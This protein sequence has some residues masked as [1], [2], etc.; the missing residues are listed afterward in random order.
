M[1][2][3]NAFCLA[4]IMYRSRVA[5]R[6]IPT[7]RLIGAPLLVMSSTATLFDAWEQVSSNA[8]PLGLRVRFP[9]PAPPSPLPPHSSRTRECTPACTIPPTSSS[10]RSLARRWRTSSSLRSSAV[11]PDGPT[12]ERAEV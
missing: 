8:L 6:I 10:E 9:R 3:V 4:T 12:G 1:E 11:E 5:P 7:L 2:A